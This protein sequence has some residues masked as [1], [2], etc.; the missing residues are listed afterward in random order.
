[1]V[2]L[3]NENVPLVP[4]KINYFFLNDDHDKKFNFIPYLVNRN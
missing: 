3:L 4:L 1:M 2:V